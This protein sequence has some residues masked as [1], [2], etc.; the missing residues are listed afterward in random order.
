MT[1]P[2]FMNAV[3]ILIEATKANK[4]KNWGSASHLYTKAF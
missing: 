2:S 1:T 4:E 3:K